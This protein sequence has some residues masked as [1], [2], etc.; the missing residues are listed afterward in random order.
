MYRI[1]PKKVVFAFIAWIVIGVYVLFDFLGG[2]INSGLR[3]SAIPVAAW[4]LTYI[5]LLNPVWRFFWNILPILNKWVFPDLNGKWRVDLHSNWSRQ[6]Q[7]LEAAKSKTELL[8]IRGCD[9]SELAELTHKVLEAEISQGWWTFEMKLRN[10]DN[11]SPIEKSLTISIDPFR[12]DGLR[13][14]GI[15]YIYKQENDT[16]NV[17]D[18]AEFYGAARLEYDLEQDKLE[19]LVWT[20]RMWKRAM[21]TASKAVFTRLPEAST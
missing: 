11:D 19:G 1:F 12:R 16:D 10:P 7:L 8:D 15:C 6:L 13:N 3:I 17:S 4:M 14:P 2:V 21:N 5:L 18:D 9:E 20:A